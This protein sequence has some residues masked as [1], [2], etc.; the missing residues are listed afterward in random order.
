MTHEIIPVGED[1]RLVPS[2]DW[3]IGDVPFDFPA[4]GRFIELGALT[5]P[6]ALKTLVLGLYP[7]IAR[8]T[9][10][11]GLDGGFCLVSDGSILIEPRCCGDL[12][13][14][15]SWETAAH[16]AE[17][18]EGDGAE[19]LGWERLWIGH[20]ELVARRAGDTVWI[21]DE[22]GDANGPALPVEHGTMWAVPVAALRRAVAD[23]SRILDEAAPR[24]DEALVGVV[25]D[26]LRAAACEWMLWGTGPYHA[27]QQQRT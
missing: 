27:L 2:V 9:I 3:P 15:G 26:H 12:G 4:I 6:V 20:P 17:V 16:L 13:D 1:V 22:N 25:P 23:A 14:L 7:D 10:P 8:G 24:L 5:D 18:R 19:R 21:G 11:T